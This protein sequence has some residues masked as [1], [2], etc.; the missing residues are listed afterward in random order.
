MNRRPHAGADQDAL[1]DLTPPAA[2]GPPGPTV[3]GSCVCGAA[4]E[5]PLNGPRPACTHPERVTARA[6]AREWAASRCSLRMAEN[7]ASW[8]VEASPP[9]A[10]E[11]A[12]AYEQWRA[13]MGRWFDHYEAQERGG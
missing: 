12:V 13:V 7:F 4:I 8:F 5:R 9:G 6:A 10:G 1:F 11:F 3:G 2:D